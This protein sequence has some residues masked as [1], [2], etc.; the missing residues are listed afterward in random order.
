M[1]AGVVRLG[2]VN[3]LRSL[4]VWNWIVRVDTPSSRLIKTVGPSRLD[5][6]TGARLHITH[7]VGVWQ[8]ASSYVN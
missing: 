5:R 7:T 3:Y 1:Y 2:I 8:R 4:Y 6:G